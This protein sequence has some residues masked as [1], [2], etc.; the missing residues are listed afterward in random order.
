MWEACM[1]RGI[2]AC[3][4]QIKS[5]SIFFF[6]DVLQGHNTHARYQVRL[7]DL[8]GHGLEAAAIERDVV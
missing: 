6:Q 5:A 8:Y 3:A 7:A 2:H 1:A 4:K